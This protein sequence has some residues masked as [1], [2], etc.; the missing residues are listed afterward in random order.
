V[1]KKLILSIALILAL[2]VVVATAKNTGTKV[3]QKA[4][5]FKLTDL[6]GKQVSLLSFKG[7]GVVLNFWATWC[8]PCRS[9]LP[10]FQKEHRAGK[11]Y[12]VVTVNLRE[13]KKTVQNFVKKGKYTFPVLLDSQGKVGSLYKVRGIPTTYFIDK[14]GTVREV[15]VGALSGKQLRQKIK[16]HLE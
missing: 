6:N 14:D 9:E 7:R 8:G 11:K 16:K 12:R 5:D 3:G 4:P 15:V 1:K 10:D 13:D 2:A